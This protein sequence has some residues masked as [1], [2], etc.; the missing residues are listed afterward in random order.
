M[1][2]KKEVTRNFL[3]GVSFGRSDHIPQ[4]IEIALSNIIPDPEQPRKTFDEEELEALAN[5]IKEKGLLQPILVRYNPALEGTYII[6][7]GERR[8]RAS[9]LAG[10]PS[11]GCIVSQGDPAELA[12][13]EN[14]V[15]IDLNPI[16]EA[17]AIDRLMQSH[18]YTQETVAKILGKSRVT[19]TESLSI[20]R[21][22]PE[23]REKIRTLNVKKSALRQLV[24]MDE[25]TQAVAISKVEGG[26]TLT[27]AAAENMKK[28]RV[29]SSP[30]KLAIKALYAAITRLSQ[31]EDTL[32]VDEVKALKDAKKK[33]EEGFKNALGGDK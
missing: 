16:E 1:P 2:P 10:L 33:I 20:L 32:K 8:Y 7:A 27:A 12:L 29:A 24:R 17:E 4:M 19:I 22:P 9:M 3:E 30:A 26:E 23:A 31:I 6:I 14:I 5:S 28:E 21:L 18:N 15:R 25:N 13:I 11:I